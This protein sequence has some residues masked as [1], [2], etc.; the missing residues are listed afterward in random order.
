MNKKNFLIVSSII[1]VLTILAC[2]LYYL[3]NK[4][5]LKL[6]WKMLSE[7]ILIKK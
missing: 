6:K 4:D 2:V 7:K 3:D 1:I 5:Q